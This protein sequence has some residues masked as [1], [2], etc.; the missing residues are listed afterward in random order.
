MKRLRILGLSLVIMF[1]LVAFMSPATTV[2]AED[3]EPEDGEEENYFCTEEVEEQHKVA[4]GIADLYE[5]DYD[6]VIALF[7]DPVTKEDGDGED[8][9]WGFGQ[10]ML[11]LETSD[12]DLASAQSLLDQRAEGMGW[13]QIWQEMGLIGKAKD[14]GKAKDAGPPWWAGNDYDGEGP[15]PWAGKGKDK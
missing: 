13:G 1:A 2:F 9:G 5:L 4:A 11:A 14:K 15:P 12:G 7:C 6:A 8:A 10:I 3:P